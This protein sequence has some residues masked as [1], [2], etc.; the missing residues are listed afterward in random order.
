MEF[1]KL[2]QAGLEVS[3]I[4]LGT[5]TFG[6]QTSLEEGHRQIAYAWEVG[7]NFM[8]TAEMYSV[9]GREETQ[10]S[11]ETIIGKWFAIHPEQRKDWVIASKVTGPS[12]L[13]EYISSDLRFSPKRLES[14]LDGSLNRLKTDY[15]DLYQLH[16]PERK[17]NCFGVLG[18]SKHDSDWKDN[19]DEVADTLNAFIAK[20]K[21]RAWGLS[22]ETP[23]GVLR[24]L[25]KA[26][27]ENKVAPVSIQ[28]PYNLLNRTFEIGLSEICMREKLAML[29]YSP[30]AFGL[31]T[32]KYHLQLDKPTD[33]INQ[34]SRLARYNGQ[35]SHSATSAYLDLAK[36]HGLSLTELA[37]SFVTSRPFVTSLI[38]GAT[39]L[40]QLKED[41]KACEVTLTEEIYE[42][43]D[44]IHHQNPNP[45]P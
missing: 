28:N 11:T 24:C 41:I 26:K 36:L 43:L 12:P 19:F 4:C 15:I 18:Y 7:I 35:R 16:W 38:L 31:L 20:G 1:R 40:D 44:L 29:A 33:R 32:G 5:M 14:A 17:T 27:S 9:P 30:L 45:A 34:F 23:W 10:G 22:N 6:E 2:S 25:T 42:Q 3:Q 37:L 21:I 13:F 39:T 8:D